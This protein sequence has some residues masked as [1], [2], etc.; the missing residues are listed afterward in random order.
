MAYDIESS[1][2]CSHCVSVCSFAVSEPVHLCV[3]ICACFE[4][5]HVCN[6]APASVRPCIKGL[7]PPSAW[8]QE[9]RR[10]LSNDLQ[11]TSITHSWD[12]WLLF[13]ST[14]RDKWGLAS[15]LTG[16]PPLD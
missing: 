1:L 5:I 2:G 16:E 4:A 15:I 10:V 6:D 11:S 3:S 12:A 8:G 14:G 13:H 7:L 9:F